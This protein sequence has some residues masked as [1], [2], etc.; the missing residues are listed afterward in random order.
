MVSRRLVSSSR[1]AWGGCDLFRLGEVEKRKGRGNT[2]GGTIPLN[3]HILLVFI[4][5]ILG[6]LYVEVGGGDKGGGE[7][8]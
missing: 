3:I 2:L 7:L 5:T 6:A 8:R 4:V 1:V